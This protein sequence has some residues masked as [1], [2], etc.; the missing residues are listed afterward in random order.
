[1]QN[2][3]KTNINSNAIPIALP[4]TQT[5]PMATM[6]LESTSQSTTHYCRSCGQSFQPLQHN[7]YTAQYFRCKTCTHKHTLFNNIIQS[8]TIM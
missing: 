7:M 6:V 2:N 3:I 1:M 4:M 5:I 8:C